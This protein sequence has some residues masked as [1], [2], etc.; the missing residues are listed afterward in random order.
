MPIIV[1][2]D[3]AALCTIA[4]VREFMQKPATDE[5][6]DPLIESLILRASAAIMN[7][8]QREFAPATAGLARTFT[9]RGGGVL[10]LA[11][12]ELRSA[13][14]VVLDYGGASPL[15]LTADTDYTLDDP[16]VDGVYSQV[17]LPNHD[18]TDTPGK[19]TVRRVQITGNWGWSTVPADVEHWCIVTVVTWLR[20]DVAAFSTTFR[21]DE[22]RVERPEA[23]PSAVRAGLRH[24]RRITVG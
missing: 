11:P 13:T 24:Y 14:S 20:R 4:D 8:T 18:V 3:S 1:D 19:R 7:W 10:D 15:T 5:A 6:Q 21:L 9:Y 23:L 12:Y 16:A 17:W 22:E 2:S